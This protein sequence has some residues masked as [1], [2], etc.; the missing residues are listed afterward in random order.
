MNP[1]WVREFD[2]KFFDINGDTGH[3]WIE[4]PKGVLQPFQD[5]DDVKSFI[6]SLLEE[7]INEI[8]DANLA[9]SS[10]WKELKQQLKSKYGINRGDLEQSNQSKGQA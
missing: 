2:E 6:T 5:L 3:G 4:G 8:P 7:L 1:K 10:M 9:H